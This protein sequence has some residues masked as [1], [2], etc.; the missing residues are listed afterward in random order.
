MASSVLPF[1]YFLRLIPAR[2]IW[3]AE[4]AFRRSNDP[5]AH[6]KENLHHFTGDGYLFKSV[7]WWFARFVYQ[8]WMMPYDKILRGIQPETPTVK[9]WS[10]LI[11]GYTPIRYK[12]HGGTYS[13][14]WWLDSI[15]RLLKALPYLM[16]N[17]PWWSLPIPMMATATAPC[18]LNG[19]C[20]AECWS[21]GQRGQK[22]SPSSRRSIQ[23]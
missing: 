23:E 15:C 10:H 19:G 1:V 17:S 14:V 11:L 8:H 16:V 9:C 21:D 12:Q 3:S 18:P 2:I 7:R 6:R 13:L 4:S 20:S 5:I 22:I